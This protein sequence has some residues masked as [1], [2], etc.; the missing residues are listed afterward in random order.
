MTERRNKLNSR[1]RNSARRL[2]HET[3][4]KREL[5]AAEIGGLMETPTLIAV[6]AN[7]GEQFDL[8]GNNVLSE[9]PTELVLRFDGG[10][11]VSGDSLEGIRF[12][13]A[14]GDG[15]F[16]EGNEEIITPGFLGFE[17]AT[18]TSGRVVLARFAS[19][20]A[21]DQY[22]I[23][24]SGYDDT[25]SGVVSLRNVN[26]TLF[27]PPDPA[28]ATQPTQ[29][30]FFDVEVGPRVLAVV[31]Q[32][33]EGTGANR[34]Q[35]REQIYVYFNDDPLSNPAAGI[36]DSNSSLPVVTPDFYKLIYTQDTVENT[37]DIVETPD[38]VVY[39]P[40]LN[41]AVLTFSADLSAL[42]GA[43]A[44]SGT[45]TYRLRIGGGADVPLPPSEIVSAEASADVFG[46]AQSLGVVFGPGTN[47]VVVTEGLIQ[48]SGEAIAPWP[49]AYD[50]AGSRDYRRDAQLVAQPDTQDGI[51][52]FPYNFADRYGL[53]AQNNNLDNAITEAQRQRTREVLSLYS[54]R[55]GVEFVET[56][57][58]GLQI[59]T[60]DMRAIVKS[61]DSGAGPDGA[62]SIY[63][64]N[65]L[66]PTRGVL[67]LD[68]AE[69][70]YD[71]YGA[72]PTTSRPSWF[73]EAVRGIGS[74]LGIGNLFEL[75]Q[76]VGAGGDS[77]VE[78]N[79]TGSSGGGPVLQNEPEFLSQSDIILGQALHRPESSD[80]DFYSFTAAESGRVQIESFAQR[81]EDTSLL[82]TYLALYRVDVVNGTPQYQKVSTNDDFYSDDSFIGVDLDAGDYIIGVSAAGN[83]AYNGEVDGSAIGGLTD[84]KYSLRVTFN[85]SAS[86]TITDSTGT[87]LD[88]DADGQ[89]GGDFNFWFRVAPDTLVAAAGEPRT[90]FVDKD[91]DD[92]NNGSVLSPV[93]TISAAFAAA[94]PGDIVRLLPNGGLDGLVT[95]PEDNKAYEIGRGGAG[96]AVLSDGFEFEVP[97]GVTVMIDAGS[98]V[99]LRNAKL[100]VGSESV[101]DDRSLAALQVLGSPIITESGGAV[102]GSG[103]VFFTSYNDESIGVDTN[104]LPT[105]PAPG[106]WGG[107]EFRND[108]DYAEGQPVWESEGIFLDYVS[109]A[110]MKYGGGSVSPT[111]PIV[112]PIQMRESRPTLI[113]NTITDSSDA[114][115]SADPDSFLETN[116]HAPLFQR[117]AP[118][119]S[120]YDRVGPEISGNTLIGN[121][122]NGLF[123]RV[124]TP[125]VG[126]LEP[127]TVSGRFDDTDIVHTINQVLVL[128]GQPG[129]P[130]LLQQRPDVNSVVMTSTTGGTL[131]DGEQ[132]S[133]RLSFFNK[134]GSESLGSVATPLTFATAGGAIRLDNLPPAPSEYVG[135]RLYR[136][137]PATG[138]HVLVTQLDRQATSYTDVGTS[139]GSI[140]EASLRP[141]VSAVTVTQAPFTGTLING[142]TYDYRVSFVDVF[143]GESLAS[144]ATVSTVANN[145]GSIQL[146]GL[147]D[148]PEPYVGRLIY[149][150]D[151]L[152]GQYLRIGEMVSTG[153]DFLDQG[154]TIPGL[155]RGQGDE[156]SKLSPRFDARLTIDPGTIVKLQSSRIEVGFG[157]DFYAEG[158]DGNG[159]VFTSR[160]DD[161]YGAGGT[162]D[163]NNDG[164]AGTASGGDWSGLVFRQDSTASIDYADIRYGGGSSPISGTFAEFNAV[165]IL[166]ANVRLANSTLTGNADGFISSSNR[167]GIGFNDESVIFVR[168]SQPI[169]VGNTI[170]E[171]DGAAISINPD[172]LTAKD[173]LDYGRMTGVSDVFATEKDNQGPLIAANMID[174]NSI[175]GMRIRSEI[176]TTESVWDDT[177][178]VHVVEGEVHSLTHH[179]ESGLR[180]RSDANQSLVVKFGP[181][182]RLV[183][184]GQ[185]L[186]IDDRIGGSLQVIGTP[187]NPVVLTSLN[188]NTVGA[189]FTPDGTPGNETIAAGSAAAAGDW[190]GLVIGAYSNDRNVAFVT[191][192]ERAVSAANGTNATAGTAQIIGDL[193][194]HEYAGD[195]NER[196]GFN[197]RGTINSPADQ[198]VYRFSATGGSAVYLDIDA[199][200]FGLD[201]AIDLVDVNDVVLATSDNS[202]YEASDPTTLINNIGSGAVQS[203]FRFGTG[204]VES[205]NP[206]DAGMRVILPGSDSTD[207]TYFVRVRS[208][209]GKTA[210]QYELSVRLSE[211]DEVPGSTVQLA[212]IRYATNAITVSGAPFHSPLAGSSTELINYAG[213]FDP[214]P[215]QPNSGDEYF[216]EIQGVTGPTNSP[217]K[218][219][220]GNGDASVVGN[221]LASDRGSLV[222]TG[223]IGNV[224][225]TN[226]NARLADVDIYE[227][228]LFSQQIEPDVFNSE[229][230]FVPTTFD[231][232]YADGLGRV[233]TSVSVYDASGRLILHSRDSNIA[234]D[235]GEPTQGVDSTDL[236]GGSAGSLDAFI[237]PV[238]LPEGRYYVAVSSAAVVPEALNQFFDSNPLNTDVRLMPINSIRAIADDSIDDY[239]VDF[240]DSETDIPF[241]SQTSIQAA[242]M[243]TISTLFDQTS[244]VPYTLDDIRLFVS[245]GTGINGNDQSGLVSFNPFT[246]VLERTIGDSAFGT[247]DIA[248]RDDG[249]LYT[250]STRA[251]AGQQTT[252][253]NIGN[254]LNISSATGAL[255]NE[256]DDGL[257]FQRNNPAGTDL[258]ADATAQ[259][260]VNALAFPLSSLDNVTNSNGGVNN[261]SAVTNGERF[262]AV[263][264]RDNR[265]RFGEIPDAMATNILYQYATINGE[266]TSFGSTN[267]NA[268][269][270]FNGTIPYRL[271]DGAASDEREL[272]I[273]DTGNFFATG[274][275]G[276]GITGIAYDPDDES[277]FW[278]VT[279][280]GGVHLVDPTDTRSFTDPLNA[281]N[282]YNSVIQTS[283]FGTVPIDP[284]HAANNF[285]TTVNLTGMSFG[286]RTIE[287]GSLR[288][289]MF[290][291]TSD[292]WLYAFK[293]QGESIVPANVFYNGRGAVPLVTFV[294]GNIGAQIAPTGL[295]FS[296]LEVNPWHQ[297]NDLGN[298]F[299]HG[300]EIPYDNSRA[301]TSGGSSLY[302]GFEIDGTAANNTV[303][304]A[305]NS[306]L[307]T[308][309]PGG[310][311]GS[312]VSRGFSL[313]G[314]DSADKPTLYFNYLIDVEDR[315]DYEIGPIQ[316]NDS[317]RVFGS[318]DDGE[319]VLLATNNE[320]H[321]LQNFDEYD[322]FFES[323]V[324]VQKVFDDVQ[325]WRQ[326]RV[327]ISP[328]AG[329]ENVKLR[330]DF[331]TA[332]AMRTQQDSIEIVAVNGNDI[333]DHETLTLQTFAPDF[334][335]FGP[336]TGGTV[337]FENIVGRDVVL[338][339]GALLDAGDGFAV[340]G[341]EGVFTVNFVAGAANSVGDVT[342]TA[343][344]TA[345]EIAE[346]VIAALP[347]SLRPY[348]DGS[349]RVSLLAASELTVFGAGPVGQSNPVIVSQSTSQLLVP[350]GSEMSP[351]ESVTFFGAFAPV[352][353]TFQ[354]VAQGGVNEIVY[355][356]TDS[357]QDIALRIHALLPDALGGFIDSD[358]IVFLNNVTPI[359][360]PPAP[361]N[362][363]ATQ[364]VT[365]DIR[366]ISLPQGVSLINGET[367]TLNDLGPGSTPVVVR[368]VEAA[369]LP[370]T[371]NTVNFQDADSG[372]AIAQ[373]LV[374]ALPAFLGAAVD[375]N[376]S[377]RVLLHTSLAVVADDA[378]TLISLDG[379]TSTTADVTSV[380]IADG[381]TMTHG[382]QLRITAGFVTSTVTFAKSG[383]TLGTTNGDVVYFNSGDT[384]QDI[385]ESILELL[386]VRNGV[387]LDASG[388]SLNVT[389][390]FETVDILAGQTTLLSLTED[391]TTVG[392]PLTVPSGS[393]IQDGE[394]LTFRDKDQNERTVQFVTLAN[395]TG[396]SNEV[397][398][399]TTDTAEIISSALMDVI[400]TDL[401]PVL[402]GSREILV[403]NARSIGT[404]AGSAV[405]S[406][407]PTVLDAIP[408]LVDSTMSTAEVAQQLQVSL[409]E[410]LGIFSGTGENT[411]TPESFKVYGGDRIRLFHTTV[412][413][414]D[415]GP[416]GF[417]SDVFSNSP[418]PGDIFGES[419][420]TAYSGGQIKQNGALNNEIGGVYIDDIVVGFAE[421]GEIVFNAPAGNR[422]FVLNPETIPDDLSGSEGLS[423]QPEREN[424]TLVGGYSLEVRTS[425]EYGV[426]QDYSPIRFE[427]DEQSGLGRSFDTNDRL[428]DSAVTLIAQAGMFLLDGDTF[429]IDDGNN[430]LTFEFDSASAP[431]IQPGRVAVAFDPSG[432]EAEFTAR[433]IRDA[434]NSQQAQDVIDVL[435]STG[436]SQEA[437][438]S[439]GNRVELFGDAI[440]INPGAGRFIKVDM[441]AEETFAGRSSSLML[442]IV[443]HDLDDV[444]Y[445]NLLN[446]LAKST[447]TSYVNGNTDTVVVSGKIGDQV[448]TGFSGGDD[449]V[450]LNTAPNLDFDSVR[451]FLDQ[452]QTIE[453]DVDTAGYAQGYEVLDHPVI[454]VFAAD[455]VSVRAPS[456]SPFLAQSSLVAPTSAD[457]ESEAG[458]FLRFSAPESGYYDVGVSS[459]DLFGGF[460]GFFGSDYGEYQ[461]TIRPDATT[462]A[463]I[464][465]RDV[466]MVDYHYGSGD[467]NRT[468]DQ[469]QVLISSN[470]ISNSSGT[471]VLAQTSNGT[472]NGGLPE[473]GSARLLRNENSDSL[474]PGVVISNNVIAESGT[475]GIEFSGSTNV[476]GEA[477]VPALFGRIVN[478][479]VVNFGSGIGISLGGTA[480]PTVLNNIVSG[481]TLGIDLQNSQTGDVILGGNAYQGN[482]Q[483]LD[484]GLTMA[485]SSFVI[486]PGTPLFQDPSRGI[487]IPAEGSDVI[488]S[489]FSSLPDRGDFLA[490]VKAPLGI[491]PSPIIAP[492]FDAFGQARVDDPTVATPGGV[493]SNVFI[494]RGAVDRADTDNPLAVLTTP[495]DA[496]AVTVPDG[497]GDP[498]ES[499]VK[500]S[501]GTLQF[502]EVQLQDNAGTGLDPETITE[503]SVLLTENGRTLV[504]N[505][506]Y[507][508][509]YS[510]NSRTI[511]LTPLSGLWRNDAV[512]EIT[513]N[514]QARNSYVASNGGGIADGDQVTVVDQS[515][516]QSTFEFDSGYSLV[517]PQTYQLVVQGTDL[518]FSDRDVFVITSPGGQT[519]QFEINL[520]GAT[521]GGNVPVELGNTSTVTEVRDAI[522]AAL[523]GNV[524]GASPAQSIADYLDIVPVAVGQNGIQIGGLAGTQV[525]AAAVDG[526]A[527]I[528]AD[529]GVEEGQT[530]SY[531]T[532]GTTVTFEMDSDGSFSGNNVTIPF[533]RTS[534]PADIAVNI[535]AA[536]SGAG[537]GLTGVQAIAGGSVLIGGAVGDVLDADMS[538]L[539]AEGSPGIAGSLTLSVPDTATGLSMAGTTFTV[540]VGAVSET[541]EITTDPNATSVNR[542][543]L[544]SDADGSSAIATKIAVVMTNAFPDTTMPVAVGDVI[545]IGEQSSTPPAGEVPIVTRISVETSGLI[546][547]GVSGG[548]IEVKYIPSAQF[549]S[550]AVAA[551]LQNAINDSAL[552]V[553]SSSPGGGT[554]LL[555]GVASIISTPFDGTP[556]SIGLAI[557]AISDV[558]GNPV[559]QNRGDKETRFT[560]IMPDVV[561]DLGDA[562]NSYGTR[563]DSNGARHTIVGSATPRFGAYVDT[564][565]D[566][567]PS[568][569]SDDLARSISASETGALLVV[570]SVTTTTRVSVVE[571]APRDNVEFQLTIDGVLT[572]FELLDVS[573]NPG[574]GNVP[575]FFTSSDD[576]VQIA[577]RLADAVRQTVSGLGG[578]VLVS[579][580]PLDPATFVIAAIDDEDGIDVGR[581]LFLDNGVVRE[582][583]VF[584]AP[585][586]DL[587]QVDPSDVLGYLNPLDP[588]GSNFNV[589]IAGSGLIDAWIDWDLN[590]TFE[591]DE[592]VLR[593]APVI[594]GVN[595]L[596]I[597]TPASV[598]SSVSF[599]T[600][601]RFRISEGGNLDPTGVAV[602]GEVEDYLLSVLPITLPTPVS[603]TFTTSEDTTLVVEPVVA[604]TVPHEGTLFENDLDVDSQILPTR[605]FIGDAPTNGTVVVTD[606]LT[607]SFQYIPNADFYGTDTFTYRVSTQRNENP[608]AV[609][610]ATFAT[611]TVNVTP[612]N[613]PPA[614]DDLDFVGVEDTTL[615][616]SAAS[617]LANSQ[618]HFDPAIPSA[619]FDESSQSM[620]VISVTVGVTRI[621]FSNSNVTA[622]T[623]LG[624]ELTA[625]FALDGSLTA[626]FY[627]PSI[628]FNRDNLTSNGQALL[629]EFTFEI[630]DDGAL[631]APNFG[632][633]VGGRLTASA[634]ARIE[635]TPQNDLPVL[636]SELV[637]VRNQGYLNYFQN[638]GGT[639]PT[640]TEDTALVIPQAFLLSNDFSG[641]VSAADEVQFAGGNDG[642]LSIISV[643]LED[644]TQGTISLL[645]D[646]SVSF[647]PADDIYGEVRFSY[648]AEDQGVNE[649]VDGTRVVSPLQSTVTS[650]IFLEPVNDAPVAFDRALTVDEADEPNG[651]AQLAFTASDLV[652]G[653][654]VST[655]SAIS[656]A[657]SVISVP[658]GDQV[659]DGETLTF[660]DAAG[661][662]IVVEFNGTGLPSVGS[663]AV[664]QFVTADTDE[665]I[666]A[667][668]QT[669]VRS[670]GLGANADVADVTIS[671]VSAA[672]I[673]PGEQGISATSGAVTLP[674]AARIH[675]GET[676]TIVDVSGQSVVVQFSLSGVGTS[677][678]DVVVTYAMAD[679]SATLASNLSSAL[680]AAGYATLTTTAATSQ[681][682]VSLEAATALTV[683]AVASQM[684]A[685]GDILT[686]V[687]G[688]D[689]IDGETVTV[690]TLAGPVVIEFNTTGVAAA[691]STVAIQYAIANTAAEIAALIETAAGTLG[692]SAVAFSD[693]ET[694]VSYNG[695]DQIVLNDAASANVVAGQ[696]LTIADGL[697]LIDGETVTLRDQNGTNTVIEFSL[698]TTATA[699]T[700]L[701]VTYAIS[702]SADEV[703]ATLVT[704]LRA[705]GFGLTDSA[706]VLTF[707]RVAS[708]S[709]SGASDSFVIAGLDIQVPSGSEI[710]ENQILSVVGASGETARVEFNSTGVSTASGSVAVLVA[711][712]DSAA[713]I[714]TRLQN[715]IRSIG[716]GAM[717]SGDSVTLSETSAIAILEEPSVPGDFDVALA[718]PFN[719]SEQ[720]IRV[721]AFET[722]AGIADVSTLPNG[723]GTLTLATDDGG[724]LS[725]NFSGGA[726]IAGIYEPAVDY[727]QLAPFSPTDTFSYFVA[728]NGQT[729]I[730]QP[731]ELRDL[732]DERSL[733]AATVTVTVTETNDPP[734]FTTAGVV[735]VLEIEL[736]DSGSVVVPGF[737]TSVT[738]GP[739]GALDELAVQTVSFTVDLAQSS[740]PAGLMT[741]GPIVS[742]TGELTVFPT[743]DAFGTATYVV[744]AVDD[745]PNDPREAFQTFTLN[746]QPVNDAPRIDPAIAG[747]TDRDAPDNGYTVA[748][749]DSNNDGVIDDGS[750]TYD[751]REDNTQPTG[752]PLNPVT[753]G[754]FVL[755]LNAA[756]TTGG[757]SR[758]GLLDVFTA[759]PLNEEGNVPSGEQTVSLQSFPS[760]TTLGGTL[761]GVF[762]A[763]VLVGISY[764]PPT[765][766]NRDI[767]R[768]DSFAY[769]VIDDS[770]TAGETYSLATS[771]LVDDRL[772]T[773]NTVFLNLLPVNDR[774]E[775]DV[776]TSYV[777]SAEDGLLVT[778][779]NY[780]FNVSPGPSVTAFDEVDFLTG[781]DASFT[782]TARGIADAEAQQFFEVF[783]NVTDQGVLTYKPAADVFGT[784]V[785]EVV[786][787]DNGPDNSTRGDLI[788]SLPATLTIDI[789][790]VNDSPVLV[791]NPPAIHHTMYEDGPAVINGTVAPGTPVEIQVR[792]NGT[793]VGLLDVFN[794]G[795]ANES[796]DILPKLGG[797]QT[798]TLANPIPA[799]TA[800]GGTLTPVLTGG[801]ITSFIYTPRTHF[802]GTDSFIYTVSDDGISVGVGTGGVG[803]SDPRIASN[804]VTIE[805]LPVND[806]PQFSGAGNVVS[807][808]DQGP[809]TVQVWGTNVQAGPAG[810]FDELFGIAPLAA[811]GLSFEIEQVSSTVD[812]ATMPTATIVNGVA[813]LSYEA[814][815]D[816]NGVGVFTVQLRDD[817]PSDA[818]IGDDNLSDK[819]TFTIRVNATNDPPT[820]TPGSTVTV[821]E[822]SGSY[823]SLWA[824]ETSPGPA[825]ESSQDVVYRVT[826]PTQYAG[827]F[828]S[829]PEIDESGI[830][831]FTPA[832]DAVGTALIDVVAVDSLDGESQP[833]TLQIVIT[834]VNDVPNPQ[835]DSFITDEDSAFTVSADGV[836]VN[837]IDPDLAT[838]PNERLQIV[839]SPS[840]QT[841]LG[842]TVTYDDVTNQLTY[843]PTTSGTLQSLRPGAFLNDTFSYQVRDSAGALSNATVVTIRVD[844]VN[845]A[846][847]LTQDNPIYNQAGDTIIS[848]LANDTDVDGTIDV[849]SIVIESQPAFGALE[850][851]PDGTVIYRPFASF[852][853]SDQFLY[854]VAD[855]LG[856]RSLP[857][858]VVVASNSA[859]IAGDDL[860]GVVRGQSIDIDLAA[861]DSDANGGLDL[862]SIEIVDAPANGAVFVL[863][864]GQVRF[865]TDS[866]FIGTE[867]FTYTIADAQGLRSTPATVR[868][869]VVASHLQNPS[870][871][872]DVNASG[873]VS[874]LD[875]LLVI[876]KLSRDANGASSIPVTGDEDV[877]N[878]YDVNGDQFI[879]VRDALN[880]INEISRGTAANG[881]GESVAAAPTAAA[882]T[883]AT[884]VFDSV[885]EV[886]TGADKLVD[887]SIADDVVDSVASAVQ[888]ESSGDDDDE[889]KAAAIDEAMSKLL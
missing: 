299:D 843:D 317:F 729:T 870:N 636:S 68:A 595:T 333:D 544:V 429:V 358:R 448:A 128:Q 280:N 234:D 582:Y 537:L 795:P 362:T 539:V 574:A 278:A 501:S 792:G 814:A 441:V 244:L 366:G 403:L 129:G 368:F 45:G 404:A 591:D 816:S 486:A 477:S 673:L 73:V 524:P 643:A 818:T 44:N 785:F 105:T 686:V 191:E 344:M 857:G 767:G 201:T 296:T 532:A 466:V 633:P 378:A 812:F 231:I 59:V 262:L 746:V 252:S 184:D 340:T 250:F 517:V 196:L 248:I 332:G 249:E 286:P 765:D 571:N 627:K 11:A 623:P 209:D 807:D 723:T 152:T 846:P 300:I 864:G 869:V 867:T 576:N 434:I 533:A 236:T 147:P 5:L 189:G 144:V 331:S 660:T 134:D 399:A 14:G 835:P 232:D 349:G 468:S 326:A 638:L 839:I 357:A 92:A 103:E 214:T 150:S 303:G 777:E 701:L 186:D 531:T 536:I 341:P 412:L 82:D 388:T 383:R 854:S 768:S 116:F 621:D 187:G 872:F 428:N 219:T 56:E 298:D 622:T 305:D 453:I 826:T 504:P 365:E 268:D 762:E 390:R 833:V 515:G 264:E 437:G 489:S 527:L 454:T 689:L 657:G 469:G 641:R 355:S 634:T 787:T 228:D 49:G 799:A 605:F 451:I 715:A 316:Q 884:R 725:L 342:F 507:T 684:S 671:S 495:Q 866:T 811:Q 655:V 667:R 756:A 47:S 475:A 38:F 43:A 313:E 540:E 740:V 713:V 553:V 265:G 607:G 661:R 550:S 788:S 445:Q 682:H 678:A 614:S 624:G 148:A 558:A 72:S 178:I 443:D 42:P 426:P 88:G 58:S 579:V 310:A 402:T 739:A 875:A 121:S 615:E 165:E 824:T 663:D 752:D 573:G 415:P 714:A 463:E 476:S 364:S 840:S 851:R 856:A 70:W 694:T 97:Q 271:S 665:A 115:I 551:T 513:L 237:G 130:T 125:A 197:I 432:D 25:D 149:R 794:P 24:L 836:L 508:F 827:L 789:Q 57:D 392:V 36:V 724:S 488:D 289:V 334:N 145:A 66:D 791:D 707:T 630:E 430:S 745:D 493:G 652:N 530:F 108:V 311:H 525:N 817:G 177:D 744:R 170:D 719:E 659:I 632:V 199:T 100:A 309:S 758:L 783:P 704:A 157:S 266:A 482:T 583:S 782:V 181:G 560:I 67:V 112:T 65:D 421:R 490:T 512:Y 584:T 599:D 741:Q 251:P 820:F 211:T 619:P 798:I 797:N 318:G 6:A 609:A 188:D 2:N 815:A 617:L 710:A 382:E 98:I 350:P 679:S 601:G 718:A 557:P 784:F 570:D 534:T 17:R 523:G 436:D 608:T 246:G 600:W 648:V 217:I 435:A 728:D 606:E 324:P 230:R 886:L 470:Q 126:E 81:L 263:G 420:S 842:A 84:G 46:Q 192:A 511:R 416:Y 202:F 291:T 174:G 69:N 781:Q 771:G 353:I 229:N 708:A 603:D 876:N 656:I 119:T 155:I 422:N 34:T 200:S 226:V 391:F 444:S 753:T 658:S 282:T 245:T 1:I 109:H 855:D 397:I 374:A 275:D 848:P 9:S 717:A 457:G 450:V 120:D 806:E 216:P 169:L 247:Q 241:R 556:A 629:D 62:Y 565:L 99:K 183:A 413:A 759:G 259:F 292:G 161:S 346:A 113:Y 773:T 880:V 459:I 40:A 33:I 138:D 568:P 207:N 153:G 721:V 860:A 352:T 666:A 549:S 446:A 472:Q 227:V 498:D 873:A 225:S 879:S 433:T 222:V 133:Y 790:P 8:N 60:G 485:T 85:A 325:E 452:G 414:S 690:D 215:G 220:F 372:T 257:V 179:Y 77:P 509:G 581:F 78:P 831:S 401:Q 566:G 480:S 367:L 564:E 559:R 321:E 844:G 253:G 302:F 640:P 825:D 519:L 319:W 52:I 510:A 502:F 635:V 496:I 409:A 32:P 727:N 514:N 586:A 631:A 260:I 3:L 669:V 796:A 154:A 284:V 339:S 639:A 102:I 757:Y 484:A 94:S 716:F 323:G 7:S 26:D 193:A 158:V 760:T 256:G 547:D 140:L 626:V 122:I 322:E 696:V 238:E 281:F 813:S 427:L 387:Y 424:E 131:V 651:P 479:T 90:I 841:A 141:D 461:M 720:T 283:Y 195:E 377:T 279:E 465:D 487:Y 675:D 142:R 347:P 304:R 670:L 473:P 343:V 711:P 845:D 754:G 593:N 801:V 497:D 460:F 685:S 697:T 159:V 208:A 687:G 478:N 700:D 585:G 76:G 398:Y 400:P 849:S 205:P 751:L 13:S 408:I 587:D 10:P 359:L 522:L 171:N 393:E 462:S 328:L 828:S 649:A 492:S 30:I 79:S 770:P 578:S 12:I 101:D 380:A 709:N 455:E 862:S 35:N 239:S 692:A 597:F 75:P 431:G 394:V 288:D 726:F 703:A 644:P 749:V 255:T 206:L 168:G 823:R 39:D 221:V 572:V 793:T 500:L 156:G 868:V 637:G 330:F 80:V 889:D 850:V 93:R 439:T 521:G 204:N 645:A 376:N 117:F 764:T 838:N 858:T 233:N 314:Y 167:D 734:V 546:V 698:G 628:D 18:D 379:P 53:D 481:F 312:V 273:I 104:V 111:E 588:A 499:F 212:D 878:Y 604:P 653:A 438:A 48:N 50:A 64:I 83:T 821:S 139:R 712:A 293:V 336:S 580:D 804:T 267:A 89:E 386:D 526:L 86:A 620:R 737:I 702:Q 592:Q 598:N 274:G 63:R 295:A 74:L 871:F 594:D 861:N 881:E 327:D 269:R 21:D 577:S 27:C 163:T 750:I 837:D 732:A 198:D 543:V 405:I 37:D 505:Q 809:V 137:D 407:S 114:A 61:A 449:A 290:G 51:N 389:G 20:L 4:E 518:D 747:T 761:T 567:A 819:K 307:G 852:N 590:G 494:D 683:D 19:T 384:S 218:A 315:D 354:A 691:G 381:L 22:M 370:L 124:E 467:I 385:A 822:D 172:S 15:S 361:A 766:Y 320:F 456:V 136:L 776:S 554:L 118:F 410:G 16:L 491:S 646:G 865:V 95:T 528:G 276:G 294:G 272:G 738:P 552:D 589:T 779:S 832:P 55:L 235:R 210:G 859:P 176:L 146:T 612:V 373:R 742:S 240:F 676:I 258:Q 23:Q 733:V 166:Q 213:Q 285:A 722:S 185:G 863:T 360:T 664:V 731:A 474:I 301:D 423:G 411:A 542:L 541:F 363:S 668:L 688:A 743:P 329:S 471:G 54:E 610:G 406:Y 175:N 132:Y 883:A 755:P 135:R 672:N 888:N 369:G 693:T 810:A 160:L 611:V 772:T 654:G 561:F 254:Y 71:G 243:S 224:N 123:V 194:E 516:Y 418:V 874:A 735:D 535:A 763:G 351:G 562:P 442:P 548:A 96:N 569:G 506:D 28:D 699:G 680:S 681:N 297:T 674:A 602:G 853:G 563:F 887:G 106:Q 529:A 613:D 802:N 555:A 337:T 458:A 107:I 780:A 335:F 87:R 575:V 338:P 775:F 642:P 440:S 164:A 730:P 425:D 647:I 396:S 31:P 223:A 242:E 503:Q 151:P 464:P 306:N 41:R 882:L 706:N 375:P 190:S 774:P 287:G 885:D 520:T 748:N 677:A 348:N 180:L 803:V 695:V 618:P 778:V 829:L 29:D 705:A 203:L 162:F 417:S 270:T 538:T 662:D 261:T 395:S 877:P 345:D 786:L 596:T 616:I 483:D 110:N 127:M 277:V 143:G 847:R 308:L 650:A 769:T 830:L 182:A 356:D 625:T 834:E 419:R 173:L 447:V 800:E 805:V 91:G 736:S 808:E 545:T 371:G